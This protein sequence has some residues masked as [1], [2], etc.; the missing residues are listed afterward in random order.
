MKLSS[1]TGMLVAALI[2]IFTAPASAK[3]KPKPKPK[4]AAPQPAAKPDYSKPSDVL[5][6]YITNLEQLLAL[7][8]TAPKPVMPLL[9]Q[10]SGQLVVIRLEIA[11]VRK[12]AEPADQPKL[13]AGIATCDALTK[14]LEERQKVLG[15]IQASR[16]VKGSGKLEGGPRKDVLSQGVKG[17]DLAKAVGTI[18][19]YKREQAAIAASKTSAGETDDALTAMSVNRWNKRAV[20]LRKYITDAYSRTK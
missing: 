13:D 5:A 16:S 10:A 3:G 6:P 2:A 18:A 9:E 11:A 17:G 20:E 4:P 12:T 15:D 1:L 8:R 7:Q 19:E 14:S